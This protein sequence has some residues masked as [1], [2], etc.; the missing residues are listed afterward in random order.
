MRKHRLWG[1]RDGSRVDL[2]S[3]WVGFGGFWGSGGGSVEWVAE[4][5]IE[6][7]IW[8]WHCGAVMCWLNGD[9]VVAWW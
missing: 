7:P 1:G 2:N 8:L 3:F 4:N 5:K 9:V 6:T